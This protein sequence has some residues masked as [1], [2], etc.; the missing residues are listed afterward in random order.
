MMDYKII[1]V[2]LDNNDIL[3][4]VNNLLNEVFGGVSENKLKLNT[5]TGNTQKSLY[6]AAVQND[7]I[8]GFNAFISHTFSLNGITINGYQ[9]C[10]TATSIHHRGKK[11]FQ[12]LIDEAKKILAIRNAAFIF[13]F[14][15]EN[16]RSIFLNKLGFREYS[17]LKLNMLTFPIIQKYFFNNIDLDIALLNKNSILPC[18]QELFVLK[19][20]EYINGLVKIESNDSYIWGTIRVNELFGVRVPFF[21]VGGLKINDTV[22]LPVLF[23]RLSNEIKVIYIQLVV[24]KSNSYNKLFNFLKPAATNNLIVYDLGLD[25]SLFG[26][27]FYSGVKDVY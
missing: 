24:P 10:W 15:N 2:D 21:D 7:L 25:T 27:N 20:S 17:S 4:K 19:Q 22:D 13:G 8:I 12:N 6:L 16:S 14:P 11:I 1:E 26:F 18:N 23:N 9:S 5:T 3:L